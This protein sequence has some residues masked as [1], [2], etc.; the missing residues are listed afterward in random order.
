MPFRMCGSESAPARMG[1]SFNSSKNWNLLSNDIISFVNEFHHS[2]H[3][4]HGCNSSFIT[5]APKVEDLLL[6]GDYRPM[7][8]IGCQYKIIAKILANRLSLVIPSI[9][10]EVQMAV[11]KGRK[12]IDGPLV[13][14][15]V[16]S[17][18]KRHK[19]KLLFKVDFE[20]AFD[21]LKV[22]E[23]LNVVFL[24]AKNKNYFIGAKIGVDKVPISHLQYADDALFIG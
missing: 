12:I 22:L 10:G 4:L 13:V 6:I 23:A 11:I 14:N 2:S 1:F 9:I 7:S 3:I 5:L 8:L 16:I 21:T 15:E 18:A 20:R 17:W 24:E 19:K